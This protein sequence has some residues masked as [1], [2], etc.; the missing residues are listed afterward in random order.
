MAVENKFRVPISWLFLLRNPRH[1]FLPKLCVSSP[2]LGSYVTLN[3]FMS[4]WDD[5]YCTVCT[6]AANAAFDM[7]SCKLPCVDQ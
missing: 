3:D 2:L 5:T 1:M 4:S 6:T 7:F